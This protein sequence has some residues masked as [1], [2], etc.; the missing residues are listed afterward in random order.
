VNDRW[1]P[2]GILFL[3]DPAMRIVG[4]IRA[5]GGANGRGYLH[6]IRLEP[7]SRGKGL[8]MAM[9]ACALQYLSAAGVRHAALDTTGH[10]TAAHNLAVRA[11]FQVVRHWLH[12]IK[13]L[14]G[15]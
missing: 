6:E 15:A 9:L 7:A 8:G 1:E 4:V 14:R 10:D 3:F 5:S 11:G 2:D 13:P 12:F